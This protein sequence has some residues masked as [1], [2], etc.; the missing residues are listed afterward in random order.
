MSKSDKEDPGKR[1]EALAGFDAAKGISLSED[2]FKEV[3]QEATAE[4]REDAKKRAHK[5]LKQA[6]EIREAMVKAER[7]FK[8]QQQKFNSE[9]G[10]LLNGLESQLNSKAN[11]PAEDS[12]S[13]GDGEGVK[14]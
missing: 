12:D 1:L 11:K 6:L 10:K 8:G 3:L 2:L 9:L 13:N 7:A 4:R 5:L 14:A